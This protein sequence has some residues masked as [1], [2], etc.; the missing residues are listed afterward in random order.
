[1]AIEKKEDTPIRERKRRYEERHKE[2]RKKA[3]KH[4]DT[5]LKAEKVDEINAFLEKHRITKVELVLTGYETLR[6][7]YGP[8]KQKNHR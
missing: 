8:D 5:L 3:T 6:E 4:F 1:M 2:E 7:Q